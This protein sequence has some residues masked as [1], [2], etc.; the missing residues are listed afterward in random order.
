M[1]VM[2]HK[3]TK[4]LNGSLRRL[5]LQEMNEFEAGAVVIHFLERH[6][7]LEAEYLMPVRDAFRHMPATYFRRLLEVTEILMSE[8]LD[9]LFAMRGIESIYCLKG[10]RYHEN[11]EGDQG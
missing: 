6:R 5:K 2:T 3:V 9:L 1:N 10:R 7:V 11:G 4:S 8:I